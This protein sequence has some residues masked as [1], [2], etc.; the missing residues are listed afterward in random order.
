MFDFPPP[1]PTIQIELAS[2]GI[3]KGLAQT[4]G[5]QLVVRPGLTFGDFS[6]EASAKNIETSSGDDGVESY[7]SVGFATKAGG[8]DFSGRG[9]LKSIHAIAGQ[10]DRRAFEMRLEAARKF[11]AVRATT[12]LI[13]SPDDTGS[14]KSALFLEGGLAWEV[15]KGTRIGARLG[16]RERSRAPDYTAYNVGI[17]QDIIPQLAAD[18][19]VFDTGSSELG[20]AFKRRLVASPR[21]KF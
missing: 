20:Y 1:K 18:L 14:T 21:A 11:G 2:T 19:R 8:F 15:H 17:T 4:R 7:L 16:R 9:G 13:Y 10:V 6:L 5:P 12:S 3:S